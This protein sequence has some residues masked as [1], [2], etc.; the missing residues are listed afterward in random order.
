MA[1]TLSFPRN[2]KLLDLVPEAA[3]SAAVDEV[4][5][6]GTH[7]PAPSRSSASACGALPRSR[8]LSTCSLAATSPTAR[9]S[10]THSRPTLKSPDDVVDALRARPAR[11]AR[12]RLRSAF[13][14][15]GA[16]YSHRRVEVS[17]SPAP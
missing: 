14:A 1:T 8:S 4:L 12:V 13:G 7:D 3:V 17:P 2:V 15:T 16:A 9:S 5:A 6:R 10:H 11:I